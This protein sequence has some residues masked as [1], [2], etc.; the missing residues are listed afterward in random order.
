MA[1]VAL[2]GSRF[3]A[4]AGDLTRPGTW[5]VSRGYDLAFII[6]SAAFVVFPHVSYALMGKNI[7][8]DLTVTL[9]IGGPHLF[10]TYTM[11]FV[12]PRFRERWPRYT[13]GALLLP[14]L[15]VTLAIVAL[16]LAV[17]LQL[18]ETGGPFRML[19][20]DEIHAGQ[21]FFAFYSVMLSFLLI[22]YYFDHFIFLQ[23]DRV[24]TPSFASA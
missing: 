12:E 7:Y 23:R 14:P 5:L 20:F 13:L 21:H 1:S 9:L 15:I 19:L 2:D 22:H 17:K 24:I 18:F 4:A 10:A 8:V 3:T 6:L 16:G 11:T